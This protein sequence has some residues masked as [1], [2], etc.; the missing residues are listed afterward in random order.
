MTRRST[1]AWSCTLAL[2][3]A[4]APTP[5]LAHQVPADPDEPPT[6]VPD[7]TPSPA[8]PAP[9]IAP[10]PQGS[11]RSR[12]AVLPIVIAGTQN[13]TIAPRVLGHLQQGLARGAFTL[14]GAA[15]VERLAAGACDVACLA[16]LGAA[17][18]ATFALRTEVTVNDRDYKVH[19]E[20]VRTADGTV[21][22][23]SDERC[24][25]CGRDELG[26]LVET[27]AALLRKELEGQIKGPPRV[28][29][30]TSPPGA[31]I[32]I[33]G[34]IVG[35]SPLERTLVDG[36]HVVRVALDGYIAEER[37]LTLSAGVRE[38]VD[39]QL[40]R[41]PRAAR[42]RAVGWAGVGVGVPALAAGVAL[43]VLNGRPIRSDCDAADRNQDLG[44]NC[45][46]IHDTDWGGAVALAAGAALLG[47][48][49]TL[50]RFHRRGPSATD[51][52]GLRP[53]GL[54]LVGRF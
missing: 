25:L 20:L 14:V 23:A 12:L 38:A 29:I 53:G 48:G 54:G 21:V 43:L 34:E 31:L 28:T 26:V 24:D 17:T 22:A 8:I 40:R 27:Q 49:I 42:L 3:L 45:R 44:G 19:L 51:R 50:I 4:L 35:Q 16:R 30:T 36:K 6:S 32:F 46:W 5:V 7:P 9:T 15:E 11:G 39:I 13:A 33:D 47:V 10:P 52:A 37:P 18:G 41:E 2:T 1:H